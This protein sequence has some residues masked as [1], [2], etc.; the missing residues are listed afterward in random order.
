M[1]SFT[2]HRVVVVIVVFVGNGYMGLYGTIWDCMGHIKSQV[3]NPTISSH[4][5]PPPNSINVAIRSI[6]SGA[7]AAVES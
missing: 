3:L 1:A 2:R 7:L 6:S 4:P 5:A